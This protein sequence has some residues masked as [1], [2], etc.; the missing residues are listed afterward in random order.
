[1]LSK[2]MTIKKFCIYSILLICCFN[3]SANSKENFFNEGVKL[4]KNKKYADSKFKFQQD[5]VFNPKSEIAYL[6]L[7]KI[8]KEEKND[9]QE[10]QYLNTVILLNPKNEEAVLNL[11]YLMIRKSNYDETKKLIDDFKNVCKNL[12][13]KTLDLQNRLDTVLKK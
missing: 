4:F 7:A 3:I 10:E 1:M 8:F 2:F 11:A 9:N 12:C 13:Q 5:I 6:Y